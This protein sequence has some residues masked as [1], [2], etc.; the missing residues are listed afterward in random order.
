MITMVEDEETKS[1]L[2]DEKRRI[3]ENYRLQ[4][5]GQSRKRA[6]GEDENDEGVARSNPRPRTTLFSHTTTK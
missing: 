5:V 3:L 2:R 6:R 4:Q 1:L